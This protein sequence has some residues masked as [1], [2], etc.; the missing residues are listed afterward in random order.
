MCALPYRFHLS[1]EMQLQRL[2]ELK[3]FGGLTRTTQEFDFQISGSRYAY[4]QVGK[5]LIGPTICF[6]HT[7]ALCS[8]EA[9]STQNCAFN[10][11]PLIIQI[12]F[13]FCWR[14]FFKFRLIVWIIIRCCCAQIMLKHMNY[15]ID[16]LQ[17]YSDNEKTDPQD[18]GR[19][20]YTILLE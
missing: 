12:D 20:V 17:M 5:I 10:S 13:Y 6:S 3:N 19:R 9:S 15:Y 8:W 7:N 2:I 18:T 11:R 14:G 1:S 4:M 16:Q